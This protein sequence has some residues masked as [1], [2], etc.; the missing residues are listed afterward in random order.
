MKPKHFAQSTWRKVFLSAEITAGFR[1]I[2]ALVTL[3]DI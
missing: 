1:Y 3:I 2:K